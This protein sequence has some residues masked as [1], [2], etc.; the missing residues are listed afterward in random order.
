MSNRSI[1]NRLVCYHQRGT[2]NDS[3]NMCRHP[4][5]KELNIGVRNEIV[6]KKAMRKQVLFSLPVKDC[7]H[8]ESRA[9]I[10]YLHSD[11]LVQLRKKKSSQSKIGLILLHM[12]VQFNPAKA[13]FTIII[14]IIYVCNIMKY[15]YKLFNLYNYCT[16][17][18]I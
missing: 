10:N 18:T 11:N 7:T 6:V 14:N 2:K 8:Q 12:H 3:I 17:K 13:W 4:D 1:S 16:I 9:E 5:P 15:K